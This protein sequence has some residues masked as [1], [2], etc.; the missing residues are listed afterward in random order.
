MEMPRIGPNPRDGFFVGSTSKDINNIEEAMRH[1]LMPLL[2]EYDGTKGPFRIPAFPWG[3]MDHHWVAEQLRALRNV[4]WLKEVRVG[5]FDE[6]ENYTDIPRFKIR[7]DKEIRI[8]DLN[9]LF[10]DRARV[11]WPILQKICKE[12]GIT[13]Y[14]L[15][16]GINT[17]DLAC[18]GLW[19]Q[20][21]RYMDPFIEKTGIEMEEI[22]KLTG[23]RVKFVVEAPMLQ[24]LAAFTRGNRV[25]LGWYTKQIVKLV[26]IFPE[27]ALW[28]LHECNGRLKGDAMIDQGVF[29]WLFKGPL[30]WGPFKYG[31]RHAVRAHNILM[32]ALKR[33]QRKLK[34]KKGWRAAKK[35]MPAGVQFPFA[36]GSRA[37]SLNRK[38]Y[39]SYRKAYIPKGVKVFAGAISAK[40]T[41]EQLTMLFHWFDE[42]FDQR[43]GMSSTC[44]HGSNDTKTMDAEIEQMTYIAYV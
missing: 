7:K 43:T 29:R 41:L 14:Y 36:F 26:S 31:P 2:L 22:W 3:E 34:K 24:V 42:I 4:S 9:L 11:A 37:P 19:H 16:I 8:E 12:H 15:E 25:V 44:G 6:T 40:L 20:A 13:D 28:Y 21:V 33:M 17:V 38:D 39:E 18:F 23:G 5:K 10:L 27:L 1:F 35:M 32:Y 30:N